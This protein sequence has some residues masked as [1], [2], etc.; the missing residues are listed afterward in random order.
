MHVCGKKTAQD[1]LAKITKEPRDNGSENGT[2]AKETSDK[3]RI[4]WRPEYWMYQVGRIR[5]RMQED[6]ERNQAQGPREVDPVVPQ[7]GRKMDKT[8]EHEKKGR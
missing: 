2:P 7:S 6:Q 3:C 5:P 1:R 4:G 8:E